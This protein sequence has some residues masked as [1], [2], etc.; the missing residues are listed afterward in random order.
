MSSVST[1]ASSLDGERF[2]AVV[3]GSGVGGLGAAALLAQEQGGRVAVLERHGVPGGF[4]HTF[5]RKGW[6]WDVGVHSVGGVNR[7]SSV[8][9]RRFRERA[10]GPRTG[11]RGLCLTGA[12]VCTAGVAGA[13][14]GAALC[15][16][17]VA[18]RMVLGRD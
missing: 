6:E 17:A 13:L 9:R 7:P 10:L 11:L 3:I 5:S 12:D 8:F 18:G 2:D 4:T 15:T 1:D 16:S 14:F